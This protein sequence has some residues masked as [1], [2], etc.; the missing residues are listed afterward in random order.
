MSSSS[1]EQTHTWLKAVAE[2]SRLRLLSLCASGE[3]TV[4]DLMAVVAQSQPRVSRHL[5]ILC[6]ASLLERF[7]DG[8]WVYYRVP[9]DGDAAEFVQRVLDQLDPADSTLQQD[10]QRLAAHIGALQDEAAPSASNRQFNRIVLEQFLTAP[11]GDLLDIG[12]GTGAILKLLSG[13]AARSVGIDIDRQSRWQARRTFAM[14]SLTN[15]TVRAGDM[16]QLA[17]S[18]AQFDTVVLD[19]VLLGAERPARALAEAVRVTQPKGHLLVVE[20]VPYGEAQTAEGAL[21]GLLS[22]APVRLGPIRMA[23]DGAWRYLVTLLSPTA[24][25]PS[26]DQSVRNS[27]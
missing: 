2:P 26:L 7:R 14:A 9:F 5:K 19:G 13:R 15:C 12:V 25:L 17:F 18:D 24:S 22:A 3:H 11:V 16:Y 23:N 4:S 1:L 21:R 6:D 8:S 27:A 20:H 10:H